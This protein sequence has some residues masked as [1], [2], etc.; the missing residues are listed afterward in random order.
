MTQNWSH[1][2]IQGQGHLG[3]VIARWTHLVIGVMHLLN[4]GKFLIDITGVMAKNR[5]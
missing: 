3:P 5:F 2:Y 4:G 1:N